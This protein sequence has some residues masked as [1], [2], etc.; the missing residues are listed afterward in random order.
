MKSTD[1]ETYLGPRLSRDTQRQRLLRVIETE[2]TAHQREVITAYYLEN[3]SMAQI[4]R[5][6][7]VNKS[8]VCRT[9]HRAEKRMRRCL[10][11]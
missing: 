10:R 9:I 3:R 7:G 8:T 4:A 5:A 1:S 11:Y 6:R 2:L